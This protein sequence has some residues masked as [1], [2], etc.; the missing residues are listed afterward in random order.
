MPESEAWIPE[1]FTYHNA[2]WV[3][4]QESDG[5]LEILVRF[6]VSS[7]GEIVVADIFL[8]DL[9]G[10]GISAATLRRV[11]LG[12]IEADARLEADHLKLPFEG[13][14]LRQIVTET[15]GIKFKG[16]HELGSVTVVEPAEPRLE[17][18]SARPY[19]DAFF[20]EVADAYRSQV[21]Y[22]HNPVGR[23]ADANGVPLSRA[24]RWI[25]E[26]RRRGF[27]GPAAHGKAG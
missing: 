15:L 27:L 11:P 16:P 6:V 2:G 3:R 14:D 24:Q 20:E 25:R 18:P 8:A 7:T 26:A 9:T 10:E 4:Y 17:V 5:P 21:G 19:P 13:L 22:W 23:I 1:A 12:R